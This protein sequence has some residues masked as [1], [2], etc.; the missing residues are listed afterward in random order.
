MKGEVTDS[1]WRLAQEIPKAQSTRAWDRVLGVRAVHP[2]LTLLLRWHRRD[3]PAGCVTLWCGSGAVFSH[4]FSTAVSI[5]A[6][7]SAEL[8]TCS[9]WGAHPFPRMWPPK[10]CAARPTSASP[11]WALAGDHA[12]RWGAFTVLLNR[13][14]KDRPP[15]PNLSFW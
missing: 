9:G 2:G 14:F 1:Y 10:L 8:T 11:S 3:R 6:Y 4:H 13:W 15:P 5:V 12:T 7:L